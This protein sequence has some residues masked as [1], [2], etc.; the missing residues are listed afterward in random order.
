MENRD[1]QRSYLLWYPEELHYP[2]L[3]GASVP[4]SDE[5]TISLG[6]YEQD[7]DP[8]YLLWKGRM[9]FKSEFEEESWFVD[10]TQACETCCCGLHR[11]LTVGV[12][13]KRAVRQVN[14]LFKKGWREYTVHPVVRDFRSS[15]DR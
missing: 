5:D 4:N 6:C 12:P 10:V 8:Y 13:N 14:E 1:G 9:D 11:H 3:R 15:Y 2:V 7:N